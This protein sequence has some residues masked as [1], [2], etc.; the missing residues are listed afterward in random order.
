ML[1]P[2]QRE[3]YTAQEIAGLIGLSC[4]RLYDMARHPKT[5]KFIP[6]FIKIGR[7]VRFPANEYE[8]WKQESLKNV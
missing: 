1:K 6:P 3:F 5:R 4:N 2:P 7:L 8:R